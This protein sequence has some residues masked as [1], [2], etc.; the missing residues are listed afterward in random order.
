MKWFTNLKI[1]TKLLTSFSIL[2][3]LTVFVGY[4]GASKIRTIDRS[5]SEL[6]EN[7]SKPLGD[8]GKAAANYQKMRADIR[9]IFFSSNEAELLQ[10]ISKIYQ[11]EKEVNLN[12]TK[13]EKSIRHE[14]DSWEFDAIKKNT[15]KYAPVRER[16]INLMKEG[17]REEAIAAVWKDAVPLA[18]SIQDG[19]DKLVD[20]KINSASKTSEENAATTNEAV[21]FMWVLTGFSVVLAALFG[22]FIARMIGPSAQR[23]HRGCRHARD[24]RCGGE[25][26]D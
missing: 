9:G 13:F 12:L 17:K 20:K 18:V 21:R 19:I 10:N 8:I 25:S 11:T 16:I 3:L 5:Y 1:G 14:E 22:F 26:R 15:E 24:G 4:I 23:N 6:I 7:D 2:A